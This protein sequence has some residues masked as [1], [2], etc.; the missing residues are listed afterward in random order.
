MRKEM[1]KY[2]LI[3]A[4]QSKII[5]Y[6]TKKEPHIFQFYWNIFNYSQYWTKVVIKKCQNMSDLPTSQKSIWSCNGQFPLLDKI[7][8]VSVRY[9]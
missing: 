7:I 6:L 3:A 2:I 9:F 1:P 8:I 5:I 4:T